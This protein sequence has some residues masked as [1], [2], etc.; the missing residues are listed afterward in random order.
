MVGLEKR[1][2]SF[3]PWLF[4]HSLW[5]SFQW[6]PHA[7]LPLL[8][9]MHHLYFLSLQVMVAVVRLLVS[10]STGFP[11]THSG[12]SCMDF[13]GVLPLEPFPFDLQSFW[14]CPFLSHLWQ[15]IFDLIDDP[16]PDPLS[17]PLWRL[18]KS[19]C[20]KALLIYCSMATVYNFGSESWSWD[21]YLLVAGSHRFES[22]RSR[23]SHVASCTRD[24]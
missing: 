19:T 12:S 4:S 6:N 13:L 17:F 15:V 11:I 5:S 7:P 16:L 9:D 23:Y 22:T 14:I 3:L 10:E 21:F 2:D 8:Q 20:F 24:W 18:L 1:P